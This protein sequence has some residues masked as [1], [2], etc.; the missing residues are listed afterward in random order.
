ML[1]KQG[2]LRDKSPRDLQQWGKRHHICS[3][4][5]VAGLLGE[6]QELPM[7]GVRFPSAP[8]SLVCLPLLT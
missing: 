3:G 7:R 8:C 4:N 6:E 2:G 1:L 5:A